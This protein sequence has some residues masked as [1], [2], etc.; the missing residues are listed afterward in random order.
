MQCNFYI[1][2]S[3]NP[4]TE[5]PFWNSHFECKKGPPRGGLFLCGPHVSLPWSWAIK[6]TYFKVNF[7]KHSLVS[8]F[9]EIHEIIPIFA[10][11]SSRKIYIAAR[12]SGLWSKIA[13]LINFEMN[14]NH[15]WTFFLEVISQQE[16][17][18]SHLKIAFLIN[19]NS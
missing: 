13:F 6:I 16:F 10:F 12:I 3:A 17:L 8:F 7:K 1:L 14:I 5:K 18:A 2:K 9:G 19:S 11:L 4:F 15:F